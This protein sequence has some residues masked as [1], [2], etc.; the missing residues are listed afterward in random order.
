MKSGMKQKKGT[1]SLF[2]AEEDMLLVSLVSKFGTSQWKLIAEFLPNRTTRQCRER[3][4]YY[5]DPNLNYAP[6][7]SDEDELLLKKYNELGPRWSAISALFKNRTHVN[8]K[9]HFVTIM[10]RKSRIKSGTSSDTDSK[11]AYSSSN[12]DI[13]QIDVKL[14]QSSADL[15][16][17]FWNQQIRELVEF[18]L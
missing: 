14:Y 9:N 7:T 15:S 16:K 3:Y 5:L 13:H 11:S 10:S 18:D 2:S 8:V 4:R 6:W 12:D 17:T 1:K